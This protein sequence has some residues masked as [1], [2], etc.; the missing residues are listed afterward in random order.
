M[1]GAKVV[2]G[3]G[4]EQ[5]GARPCGRMERLM[6]E[7]ACSTSAAGSFPVCGSGRSGSRRPTRL[8]ALTHGMAPGPPARSLLDGYPYRVTCGPVSCVG[9]AA[10]YSPVPVAQPCSISLKVVLVSLGASRSGGVVGQIAPRPPAELRGRRIQLLRSVS[11]RWMVMW[12]S[13]SSGAAIWRV[14]GAMRRCYTAGA[15]RRGWS[16]QRGAPRS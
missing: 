8:V 1:R 10:Y 7:K 16:V 5:R 14:P 6:S 4:R 15:Q 3:F 11:H 13:S 2:R 12:A 9:L